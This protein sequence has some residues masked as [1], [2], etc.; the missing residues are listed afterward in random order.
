VH[1]LPKQ[2]F[3]WGVHLKIVTLAGSTG[4]FMIG[5]TSRQGVTPGSLPVQKEKALWL[6]F[7]L[8]CTCSLCIGAAAS[9]ACSNGRMLRCLA[10]IY[11]LD[12]N[13]VS[14]SMRHHWADW[15]THSS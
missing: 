6:V 14:T 10:V 7:S 13:A 8:Q 15:R 5:V 12:N 3:G 1:C 2:E 4:S 11:A 9:H